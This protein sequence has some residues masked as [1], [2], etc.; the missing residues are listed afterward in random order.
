M[1]QT[2]RTERKVIAS[3]VSLIDKE[4]R[5]ILKI[6]LLAWSLSLIGGMLVGIFL[7]PAIDQKNEAGWFM[8][9]GL[10]A[11]I[12]IG[13]SIYFF[14]SLVQWPVVRRF[15]NVSAIKSAHNEIQP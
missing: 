5:Q 15:L 14:S 6:R 4:D 9:V 10:V 7:I 3:L 12:L 13:L 8:G 11:G 2:S 1:P